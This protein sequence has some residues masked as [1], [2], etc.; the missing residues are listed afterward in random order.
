MPLSGGT[1]TGATKFKNYLILNAWSGYG[2]GTANFWYDANNKYVEIEN[3]TSL[4]LAG[5]KVSKEGH[6]HSAY[7]RMYNTNWGNSLIIPAL[8]NGCIVIG[9]HSLYLVWVAG[10][11]GSFELNYSSVCG[12][13]DATF[14]CDPENG[15]I[16]VTIP[17]TSGMTYIG[18]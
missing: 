13:N 11:V 17:Y 2:T 6:T 18:R 7:A 4:K 1:V 8:A 14:T 12:N 10:D 3:A 15:K 5:T 9:H 16:T